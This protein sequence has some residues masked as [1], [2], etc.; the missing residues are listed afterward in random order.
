MPHSFSK[1]VVHYIFSTKNREKWISQEIQERL[2]KY[3]GGIARK[4]DIVPYSIGGVEDHVHM[5]VLLPRT[6]TISEA[7]QKIKGNASR[8]L[9]ENYPDLRKF[10]WQNG[11]GAFSVSYSRIEDVR[12]YIENQHE[13]HRRKSFKEEFIEFLQKHEIEYD[14]KEI[15]G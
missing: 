4:L 13:H 6:I 8:W 3:M 2:W 9:H 5:L 15:W 7:I 11:Y 12:R 1:I 14:E 10:S